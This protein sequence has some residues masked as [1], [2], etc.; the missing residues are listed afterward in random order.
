MD[1]AAQAVY[2]FL[3]DEYCDWYL[4]LSKPTLQGEASDAR[5]R[6]TRQTL[7]RVLEAVLRLAHPI[8]PFITEEIWQRLAPLA[9]VSGE[10]IIH[11]PYPQAEAGREDP[12]A[13]ADIDWLQRFI[14]GIRRIRGEMDIP[15]GKPLPVLLQN[16]AEADRERLARH[17]DAL[18]F[19]ARLESVHVLEAGEEA[20]ES[21]LALVDQLEI[22]VPMA[23]LIDR[24]A[25]LARIDKERDRIT[26]DLARTEGKLGNE[27]FVNRAPAEVVQRERDKLAEARAALERLD[28]QRARIEQL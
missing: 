28:E 17:R 15:P 25:E 21:A 5:R 18:D 4:E 16:A 7:V 23:G 27:S 6:G 10:T 26:A 19:L 22:R 3:W 14:L 11:Q 24:D 13:E 1:Q 12:A 2:E 9:G 20:P 8:M